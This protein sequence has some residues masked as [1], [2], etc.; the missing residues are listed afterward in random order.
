MPPGWAV[1]AVA[2]LAL[3]VAA[4]IQRPAA[5]FADRP[6]LAVLRDGSERPVWE[7][8]L[9]SRAHEIAVKTLR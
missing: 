6:I 8:R 5:D 4:A 1:L 3:A 2:A 7:I 9:A